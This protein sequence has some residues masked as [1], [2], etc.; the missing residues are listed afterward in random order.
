MSM[1]LVN[2]DLICK[3]LILECLV[4]LSLFDYILE[5]FVVKV[6]FREL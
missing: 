6:G 1:I 2:F 5:E 3:L 4:N